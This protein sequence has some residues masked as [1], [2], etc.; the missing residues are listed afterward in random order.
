MTKVSAESESDGKIANE[1]ITTAME[2][3]TNGGETWRDVTTADEIANL[4]AGT[5]LVRTKESAYL[6]WWAGRHLDANA[7]EVKLR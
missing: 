1:A 3:S 7:S 6:H 2:Y 4:A 5:V